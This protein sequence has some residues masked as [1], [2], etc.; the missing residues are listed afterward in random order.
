MTVPEKVNLGEVQETLLIPLYIRAKETK[1]ENPK[2][3][4][5]EAVELIEKIDYDFSKFDN[6]KGS[7]L[8]V[9]S[10]TIILDRE[11]QKFINEHPDCVIVNIGC[12]DVIEV[13]E[14]YLNKKENCFNVAKSLLDED[15]PESID[16]GD[17][18]VLL[19]A[20]GVF[21]Y[22]TEEEVKKFISIV[23]KHYKKV[24]LY[25]EIMHS[26]IAGRTKQ[27]D[28]VSNTNATFKWGVKY[29][30]DV[31]NLD[32]GVK[33]ITEWNFVDEMANF[34]GLMMRLSSKVYFFKNFCDK[35]GVYEITQTN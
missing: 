20:E 25:A 10:R 14:K 17:K 16:S 30:K 27:H 34:G 33:F 5:K 4:D 7:Y 18:E 28:A 11:V 9:V 8:G 21:M 26:F 23:K 19:L 1:S 31:E 2:L 15:W 6:A 22:F 3:H 12:A 35:F 32:P 29:A 24:T 13:R